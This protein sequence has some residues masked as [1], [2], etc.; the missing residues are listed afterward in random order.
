MDSR[1]Y[2]PFVSVTSAFLGY[3]T[4]SW[5]SVDSDRRESRI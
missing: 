3:G 2:D 1:V 5:E 4:K